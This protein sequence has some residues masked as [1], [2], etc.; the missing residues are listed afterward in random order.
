MYIA[1]AIA[2]WR[3]TS[4]NLQLKCFLRLCAEEVFAIF[5]LAKVC[6]VTLF[7]CRKLA[8]HVVQQH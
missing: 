7:R 6:R 4:P 8:Y 2:P 1:K 5:L 3:T